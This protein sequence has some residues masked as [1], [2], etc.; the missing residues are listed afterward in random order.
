MLIVGCG[1]SPKSTG[2]ADSESAA[3]LLEKIKQSGMVT[4]GTEAA[5]EPFE[6]IQDGKIVGYGS[7]ILAYIVE[8][9]GV[10][11]EQKDL[12]FQ[13]ILPGLEAKQFDFVATA[14]SITPERAEKYGMTVPIAD[15]TVAVLKRKGDDSI[16]SPEDIAGKIVGTQLGSGQLK[17][18]KEYDETLKKDKGKGTKEIK[19]YVAYPEAYQD[20]ANG[21]VDAVVNTKANLASILKK[22]PDTFEMVDTFGN[23]M[24]ISWVV[25]KEDKEL[26][27]FINEKILEMKSSGKLAELQTKW[28]GYTME[29]PESDYLPQ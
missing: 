1:S 16:K 25:R 17:A 23:K 7:D 11:V 21:R 4:V 12:P 3:N 28:F 19:E 27:D 8:Q 26:L 9:L 2:S 14:V 10:K 6:Y 22:Q 15:G 29:T 20:L 18:L 5:Y 24:W 13:G